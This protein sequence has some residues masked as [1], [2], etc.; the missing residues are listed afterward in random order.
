VTVTGKPVSVNR[1]LAALALIMMV[2]AAMFLPHVRYGIPA[3]VRGEHFFRGLPS[4]YWA[5]RISHWLAQFDGGCD[6]PTPAPGWYITVAQY[7]P[8]PTWGWWDREDYPPLYQVYSRSAIPVLMELARN[9]DREV[10]SMALEKLGFMAYGSQELILFLNGALDSEDAH[11]RQRAAFWL[12]HMGKRARVA[13]TGLRRMLAE[14]NL[15]SRVSAAIAISQIDPGWTAAIDLCKVRFQCR[16][17][18]DS[19][20]SLELWATG[21]GQPPSDF[22][23]PD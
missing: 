3:L 2:L 12:G 21:P 13:L 23:L 7:V 4:S 22:T 10:R 17:E 18:G 1:R 19:M 9:P 8:L 11:M 16:S 14:E 6:M 5:A 20:Y 15:H